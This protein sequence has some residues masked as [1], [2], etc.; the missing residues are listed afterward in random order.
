MAKIG[1]IRVSSTDQNSARQLSGIELD[2]VFED[3]CSGSSTNRPSLTALV[4]YI[5]DGDHIFVHSIDRLARNLKDLKGLVDTFKGK[6]VALT[7]IKNNLSFSATSHSPTDNLMLSLLGA[8]AEFERELIRDRQREGIAKA[9]AEGRFTGRTPTIDRTELQVLIN[10][11][12]TPK[13]VQR[14]MGISKASFYRLLKEFKGG[15]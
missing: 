1:Y 3:K 5:R 10:E 14:I 4:D 12:R 11:G 6:G 9:K 13:Q 8:V 15:D 7:F 2:K